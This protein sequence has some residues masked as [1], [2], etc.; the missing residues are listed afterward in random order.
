M[1]TS[2]PPTGGPPVEKDKSKRRSIQRFVSKFVKPSKAKKHEPTET[3]PAAESSSASAPGPST[4][5]PVAE[6]TPATKTTDPVPQS[7]TKSNVEPTIKVEEPS[8]TIPEATTSTV[9]PPKTKPA[10]SLGARQLAEKHGIEIPEDW[11]YAARPPAGERVEK[12]IRMRVRRYCH[13]CQTAFGSEKTCPSCAHKRCVECPRSPPSKPDKKKTKTQPKEFDPYEGLTMPSKTGGQ[14]LVYRKIRQRVHW[15][16]H[17]CESD[18]AGQKTCPKCTHNRC[19]KCHR[20]PSR[21]PTPVEEIKRKKPLKWTCSECSA[22]ANITKACASCSHPRC[23]DCVREVP[24]KK[25]KKA[26]L[27]PDFASGSDTAAGQS[28][29]EKVSS[30]LAATTIS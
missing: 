28:D 10:L 19:K 11:P 13:V 6:K 22:S 30:A 8:K 16:C 3:T 24:K 18:F 7:S 5:A 2:Q 20:E 29:I 21:K 12:P 27:P 26:V 25:K 23:V 1:S 17:K 14:P 9:E 15:K 4:S